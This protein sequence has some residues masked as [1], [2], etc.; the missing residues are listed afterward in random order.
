MY[1]FESLKEKLLTIPR[2]N[3]FA[4]KLKLSYTPGENKLVLCKTVGRVY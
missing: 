1:V 4:E 3:K 2:A